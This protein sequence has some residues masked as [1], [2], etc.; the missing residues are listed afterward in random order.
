MIKKR[1][2]EI[3]E[4]SEKDDLP[5]VIFDYFIITVIILNVVSVIVGSFDTISTNLKQILNIFEYFSVAIFTVE[6]I[7]RLWTANYKYPDSRLPYLRFIFSFMA[8]ID[9]CAILPFYLPFIV[10]IDLRF[11]RV[12]R[13]FRLLRVFKLNRYFV[14]LSIIGRVLKNEKDKLI[15]TILITVL[16]L[17]L[18][19][20][21]M[22][23]IENTAQPGEFPNIIATFWWAVATLTTVGYGDVYPI[24]I[25]GKILSGIM[26]I[27]GI[28]LVGLPSGIIAAGFTKIIEKEPKNRKRKIYTHK[29]RRNWK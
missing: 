28:G 20:S 17:L 25:L 22:Y 11:L 29:I 4:K 7:V 16:L 12:L 15:S 13:L 3:I 27:L 23:F 14:S 5:G 18:A 9:L 21:V 6:Y 1:I 8:L 26:A 10:G 2:F 19:S 24:T